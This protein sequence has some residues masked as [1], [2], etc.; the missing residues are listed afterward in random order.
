M[1]LE[2]AG[3]R[4]SSVSTDTRTL[5]AGAL[6]IA[7][8]GPTHDGHDHVVSAFENGAAA[9][10]VERRVDAPGPIL[11]V[12]DC[13]E[14]LQETAR[15]QCEAWGG[16]VVAV[17]G[18]AGKTTAKD[19]IA[20]VLAATFRTG[21][22][23][24]N[25]NNH[26]G[27]PLSVL[28]LPD[29]AEFAVLEMGMNHAGEIRHLATI[30][31]PDVAVVTNVGT[32][33]MEAFN[34][35]EEI[36]LA[37]RE[38]VEALPPEGVAI[39][40]ADDARVRAFAAVH[41]GPSILYGVSEHAQVRAVDITY[42]ARSTRFTVGGVSYETRLP[43]RGGVLAALAAIAVGRLY[44]IRD[45]LI[46]GAI[47]ALE[48][49]K[50]R[51]ER[52]ERNGMVV[53]NDCYNSN[54]EAAMMMLDLLAETPAT[55]RIA[56]LGEMLELGRWSKALHSDVG[57]HAARCG[58]SV[59]VGVHGAASSL[60]DAARSAGLPASA[61][62]FFEHPNEAGAFVKSIAQSGDALLFKGSRGTRVELALEEFL[63]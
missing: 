17:T 11:I 52:I 47:A 15:R 3:Q 1:I 20:A 56:V 61:A 42:G 48:P 32:A 10:V 60:V 39:L 2:V 53:W 12:P 16:R 4:C 9:A 37:K 41:A 21:K 63:G 44:G 26:I 34:S 5:G 33:H 18:S 8:K 22:T 30:A 43:A 7:L 36:A 31:P 40:N 28:N 62:H 25:F 38:L 58:I 14:W 46:Q 27:V 50:M 55:R 19:A 29:D 57:I 51:L 45:Q 23:S 13:L 59:L 24:G 49:P 6:F 35:V 54:P